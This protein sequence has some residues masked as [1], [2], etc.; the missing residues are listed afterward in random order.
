MISKICAEVLKELKR[1]GGEVP[2]EFEIALKEYEELGT[3]TEV[4][5]IWKKKNPF[6]L[7]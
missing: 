2:L 1:I 6:Q 4:N 7:T 3:T 5:N